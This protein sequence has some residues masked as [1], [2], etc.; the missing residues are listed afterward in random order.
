MAEMQFSLQTCSI[1]NCILAKVLWHLF[2]AGIGL[3]ISMFDWVRNCNCGCYQQK[4]SLSEWI[5]TFMVGLS[6]RSLLS[7]GSNIE[8]DVVL[9]HLKRLDTFPSSSHL[10]SAAAKCIL[11]FGRLGEEGRKYLLQLAEKPPWQ[12]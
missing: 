10:D 11:H 9:A 8:L 1:Q 4:A 3:P 2:E 6:L 12:A 5:A 7:S